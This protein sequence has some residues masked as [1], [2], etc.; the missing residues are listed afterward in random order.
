MNRLVS[1]LVV[2]ATVQQLTL[3]ADVD[4]DRLRDYLQRRALQKNEASAAEN[5]QR[6]RQVDSEPDPYQFEPQEQERQIQPGDQGLGIYQ[7]KYEEEPAQQFAN[8]EI[9]PEERQY[10]EAEQQYYAQQAFQEENQDAGPIIENERAYDG[11]SAEQRGFIEEPAQDV[12]MRNYEQRAAYDEQVLQGPA[13]SDEELIER[14]RAE[15]AE[16]EQMEREAGLAESQRMMEEEEF[17]AQQRA[18]AMEQE[19][20]ALEDDQMMEAF[21]V[22][23]V[24]E[25]MQADAAEEIET[26]D[27]DDFDGRHQRPRNR[28]RWQAFRDQKVIKATKY[29]RDDGKYKQFGLVATVEGNKRYFILD[30]WYGDVHVINAVYM[31]DKWVEK[32]SKVITK[33]TLG[34]FMK[35]AGVGKN[36]YEAVTNMWK[37]E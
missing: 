29:E 16:Q 31:S 8:P 22:K 7:Y 26:R 10:Q 2:V 12:E 24:N 1:L 27:R 20:R 6:I 9:N 25:Q 32:E 21:E 23:G 14:E 13:L 28:T 4:L 34:M 18:L 37:L 5:A 19:Q 35:A 36:S 30:K 15:Q 11:P 17:A 3:A 33:S